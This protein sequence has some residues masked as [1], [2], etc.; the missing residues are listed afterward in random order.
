VE[1]SQ[2]AREALAR[3]RTQPDAWIVLPAAGPD[4]ADVRALSDTGVGELLGVSADTVIK[5]A[6]LT[7]RAARGASFPL[8]DWWSEHPLPA[9]DGRQRRS[10]YWLAD[11]ADELLAWNRSRPG[12]GAG[13]GGGKQL[14]RLNLRHFDPTNPRHSWRA[15]GA[16][17]WCEADREDPD[18]APCPGLSPQRHARLVAVAAGS[19]EVDPAD[20]RDGLVG[21][22]ATRGG[23]A[24]QFRLTVEGK[25]WLQEWQDQAEAAAS[26]EAAEP[27]KQVKAAPT[28][29]A[30]RV[31]A[32]PAKPA[33]Q[34]KAAPAKATK[35]TKAAKDS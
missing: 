16:C 24:V 14:G 12:V 34:V 32:A 21:K 33:K 3:L 31:K 25:R 35:A 7:K 29:P 6:S 23:R 19:Q 9:E 26:A 10:R 18:L 4:S 20:L 28:K 17:V 1:Q 15:S 11:R 8:S 22:G 13:G 2:E 5:F 27:A 30:K